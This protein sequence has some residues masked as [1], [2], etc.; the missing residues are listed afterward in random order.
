[1]PMETKIFVSMF[2]IV[3]FSAFII[4]FMLIPFYYGHPLFEIG[5]LTSYTSSLFI[6]FSV[7]LS[8][9]VAGISV[10]SYEVFKILKRRN[11]GAK[12]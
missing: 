12:S 10:L 11:G 9:L 1:M 5:R 3:F 8:F 6:A 7:L 2:F 4:V